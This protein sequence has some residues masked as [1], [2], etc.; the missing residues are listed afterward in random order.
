M[1][2]NLSQRLKTAIQNLP[3]ITADLPGVGGVIK[4]TPEHFHV[5]EILPYE[6]CGEG[7]HVFVQLRRREWNTAD[8]GRALSQLFDIK[9]A[10][11]GWG[12]RKDKNAVTTQ[13]F[14]LRLPISMPLKEIE[15][16]LKDAPFEILH[17]KRH[18][19]KLKTGHVAAN[20]FR[21]ILSQVSS[22]AL[23]AA[24]TIGERLNLNG[25]PNYYGPQRFGIELR[26][27]DSAVGVLKRGKARGKKEGFIVSALQSALF[28]LWLKERIEK[29]AFNSMI[30]GDMAKKTDTGGMFTVED[31]QEAIQRFKARKIVYTGPIYGHK[32]RP[33]NGQ[34]GEHERRLLESFDLTPETFKAMRAPGSRRVAILYLDD[35]AIER[36]DEGLQFAFTLP[37]GAYATVV[38][39]EFIRE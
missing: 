36:A 2:T 32:M 5:E 16:K 29:E 18:R 17:L 6:P 3:Y 13:T 12:G 11:V 4:W 22:H 25:L 35:L 31:L 8:V 21:I 19:N 30:S 27:I 28:N 24:R 7:E 38:M 1:D 34:A 37:A 23:E 39:R 9:G 15:N 20:R 10:D 33:A 26:N 14:S